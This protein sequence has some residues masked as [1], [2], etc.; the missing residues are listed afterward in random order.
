MSPDFRELIG[1]DVPA[2]ER[3]R[4]KRAHD[5]LVAAGPPPELTPALE[6]P[7]EP[8]AQVSWLPRRRRGTAL[9]LAATLVLSAFAAGFL[10][11]DRSDDSSSSASFDA[12]RTVVLGESGDTVAVVRLGEA[13]KNG[14]HPLFVTVEGLEEQPKGDY[15]SLF[16]LKKGKPVRLCGTF[17]VAGTEQTTVRFVMGYGF[18]GFDG[19]QLS[20]Y[21]EADHGHTP[22]LQAPL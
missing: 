1:E 5:L 16:M 15:Y 13:D 18:D 10:I 8:G 3:A 2:E 7:P 19:L 17:N 14:N 6:S 22:L 20:E 4:L 9:V 21:S 11:G 12:E